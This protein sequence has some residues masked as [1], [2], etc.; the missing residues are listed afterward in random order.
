MIFSFIL[1]LVKLE[2]FSEKFRDINILIFLLR[3]AHVLFE[4]VWNA[5]KK[6]GLLLGPTLLLQLGI[7]A[8]P[9]GKG[10]MCPMTSPLP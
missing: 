4:I 3:Y 8:Q 10:K 9:K 6:L 5:K 1:G 2:L 7:W